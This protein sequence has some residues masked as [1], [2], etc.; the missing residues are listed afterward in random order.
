MEPK[1]VDGPL[2]LR[3]VLDR[4]LEEETR[5]VAERMA[6]AP[7][8]AC[9]PAAAEAIASPLPELGGE[10]AA[11]VEAIALAAPELEEE[12]PEELEPPEDPRLPPALNDMLSRPNPLRLPRSLG[13][14]IADALA[15][16]VEPVSRSVRSSLPPRT[17]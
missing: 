5:L 2:V 1:S 16:A 4:R 14:S 6:D 11:L 13:A 10:A 7:R 8:E 12:P 15:A 9:K 3:L 17:E